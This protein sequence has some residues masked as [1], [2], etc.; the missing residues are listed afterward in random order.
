M[1]DISKDILYGL[2]FFVLFL[3]ILGLIFG[4]A[5]AFS[6]AFETI[7]CKN[8]GLQGYEVKTVRTLLFDKACFIKINETYIPINNW[9]VLE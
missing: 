9:R 6:G 4:G 3:I 5:S 2:F 8:I 7:K 1:S